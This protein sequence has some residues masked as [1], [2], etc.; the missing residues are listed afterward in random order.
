M[1][2]VCSRTP[3]ARERCTSRFAYP[4]QEPA[5]VPDAETAVVAVPRNAAG[6]LLAVDDQNV[7]DPA[8]AQRATR[9][10]AGGTGTDDK[11]IDV[12]VGTARP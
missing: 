6:L 11:H 1:V 3:A 10:Q 5:F 12:L 8:F 4:G 7:G 9:S 2:S